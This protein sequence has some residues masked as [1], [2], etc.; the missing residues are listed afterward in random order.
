MSQWIHIVI[1]SDVGQSLKKLY[2]TE[3]EEEEEEE[4]RRKKK[5]VFASR[6]HCS[7]VWFR[8]KYKVV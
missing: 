6:W 2:S 8:N 1:V 3:E 5:T 4:E 7:F